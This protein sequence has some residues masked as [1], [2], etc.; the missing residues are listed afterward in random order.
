MAVW[1]TAV[2]GHF[3]RILLRHLLA[4]EEQRDFVSLHSFPGYEERHILVGMDS[5]GHFPPHLTLLV[6]WPPFRPASTSA[7]DP[8]QCPSS[9]SS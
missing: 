6:Y 9:G 5:S 7:L 3:A 2:K 1:G 4:V 8:C